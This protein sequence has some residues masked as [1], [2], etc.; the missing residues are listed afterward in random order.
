MYKVLAQSSALCKIGV[1]VQACNPSNWEWGR[2]IRNSGSSS[3]A[4]Q[5]MMVHYLENALR[6]QR[7]IETE[8]R[9][10]REEAS[11]LRI[12]TCDSEKPQTTFKAS[13]FN[14]K[15]T[16]CFLPQHRS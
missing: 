6:W 8:G 16:P 11:L 5:V 13:Q 14:E 3:N 2:R 12:L 10:G 9:T 7:V 15:E 1:V 4:Q